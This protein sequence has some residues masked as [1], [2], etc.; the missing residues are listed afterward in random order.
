[1][2]ATLYKLIFFAPHQHTKRIL[3][4]LFQTFPK[5]LG[6]LGNYDSCAFVCRGRG[7][8]RPLAGSNP[9]LGKTSE[10]EYVEED[11]V[12]LLVSDKG[13]KEEIR[14]SIEELK[15]VHPYEEVAYDVYKL[16]NFD[17]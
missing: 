12:E 4:H 1:M 9:F 17:I 3:S 5:E 8:F 11:R 15:K 7:Q 6:S 10:L 13:G 16:E 2:S 14:K